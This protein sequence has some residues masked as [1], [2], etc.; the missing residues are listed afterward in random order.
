VGGREGGRTGRF[1]ARGRGAKVVA[2]LAQEG[3]Q[4]RWQGDSA[5]RFRSRR[6]VV[7]A[8][9]VRLNPQR[10]G[11]GGPKMRSVV[12]KA[13]DAHLRYL[14]RDSPVR[15]N[16]QNPRRR[17]A[18]V[19][20]RKMPGSRA[21]RSDWAGTAAAVPSKPARARLRFAA[22]GLDRPSA[23]RRQARRA[24][25]GNGSITLRL[26]ALGWQSRSAQKRGQSP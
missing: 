7:K 5:G 6:L 3:G 8:R 1:N 9:V 10:R 22:S 11:A 13:V 14:E 23:A 25:M 4:G 20:T 24:A 21:A 19:A 16:L 26:D 2:S 18:R 12:S 17:I 15:A